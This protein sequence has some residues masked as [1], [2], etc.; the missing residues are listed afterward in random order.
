M[1]G[2]RLAVKLAVSSVLGVATLLSMT[3]TVISEVRFLEEIR[4]GKER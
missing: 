4:D 3:D 2:K 1:N